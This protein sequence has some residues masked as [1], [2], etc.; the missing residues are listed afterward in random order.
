MKKSEATRHM[1]LQKAFELIYVK[2][3]QATSIDDILATTKV[4]KGAFYYHFRNKEEMGLAVISE[5]LKPV[6]FIDSVH[7][8]G[9]PLESIYLL[10]RRLLLEDDFLKM[11][12]G[13][14]V[15]NFTQEMAPWHAGFSKVLDE[16]AR[17]WTEAMSSIIEEGKD[18]GL[19]RKEVDA[20]QVT[21]FVLSGYW[22]I[23]NIGK[24]ENSKSVYLSYLKEL[25]NYLNTLR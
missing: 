1:I 21:R 7:H 2:G 5:I 20:M 8:S 4:T 14:P 12:Y 18:R 13:C 10:M 17:Q 23:R 11:E 16:L 15:A 24:L 22:G 19:I 25:K 6:S 3:Y 9:D